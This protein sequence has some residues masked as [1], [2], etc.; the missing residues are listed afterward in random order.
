M[1]SISLILNFILFIA[2]SA[3]FYLHFAAEKSRKKNEHKV[4]TTAQGTNV[5][6]KIAYVDLDSLEN[7]YT[8]FKEVRASL[9]SREEQMARQL[10]DIRNNYLRQLKQYNENGPR[11]SQTEQGE[12]QQ[13]LMKLQADYQ[14]REQDMQQ[15]LQNES[16]RKIQDVK[17]KVQQFLDG[18]SKEKG[19]LFVFATNEN[20]FLYYKDKAF[21]ITSEVVDGLNENHKTKK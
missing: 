7:Q 1:K 16:L 5:A 15:E 10:N 4:A 18:Y 12:F 8:Y 3:L 11:M 17:I 6:M 19:F 14:S 9:R 20:D 21:D 13:K 2:V